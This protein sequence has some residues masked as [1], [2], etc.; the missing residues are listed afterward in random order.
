MRRCSGEKGREGGSTR[1]EDKLN[2]EGRQER[3]REGQ[4]GQ[5]GL[6]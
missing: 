2:W 1:V 3:R 6:L 5:G 4:R